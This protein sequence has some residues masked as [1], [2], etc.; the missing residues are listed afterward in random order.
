MKKILLLSL[1]LSS[2]VL[3]VTLQPMLQVLDQKKKRHMVFS[4][5]NPTKEPVAVNFD[6]QYLVKNHNNKEEREATQ[7]VTF[8]PSQFVLM[9]HQTKKVRVRYMANTLPDKEEV[10]RVI[11]KELDVNVEDKVEEV[12]GNTIKAQVKMRLTYEGLLL[13]HKPDAKDKLTV[14]FFEELPSKG[15]RRVVKMTISNSGNASSV[16]NV[17]NFDFI[18]TIGG[19]EYKLTEDDTLHAEF[20]RVLAQDDNTF[21]LPNLKLPTGKIT[22]IRLEKR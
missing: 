6:I 15:D 3:G 17:Q 22:A 11:A 21:T 2:I 5:Y 13:V 1:L 19:K 8:Y 12:Q 7:K 10:Y 18:V 14:S 16:P 9:P 4:V 20:R